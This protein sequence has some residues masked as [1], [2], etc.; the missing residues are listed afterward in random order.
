LQTTRLAESYKGLNS[1][2]AQ[3]TASY[4]VTRTW[5]IWANY[6]FQCNSAGSKGVKIL[7]WC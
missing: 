4:G 5:P 2:L 3:L 7:S 1:S 6:T